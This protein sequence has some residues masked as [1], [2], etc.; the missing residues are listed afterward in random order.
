MFLLERSKFICPYKALCGLV[1]G[2]MAE[3]IS[4]VDTSTKQTFSFRDDP[5][6][7]GRFALA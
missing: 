2:R 5:E 6:Y 4:F 1:C 3:E 7:I